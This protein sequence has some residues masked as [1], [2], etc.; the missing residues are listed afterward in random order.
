MN[1]EELDLHFLEYAIENGFDKPAER[2]S[3]DY[4]GEM[5][6]MPTKEGG[7][8][9]PVGHNYR[10]QHFIE[11]NYYTSGAIRLI[12]RYILWHGETGQVYSQLLSPESYKGLARP[13]DIISLHEGS[14]KIG[15]VKIL[16]IYNP[17][18]G[19]NS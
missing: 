12:G 1:N 3:A 16:E 7:R 4:L 5:Y 9:G 15:E 14:K 17:E 8:S 19:K 6:L 13:G 10:P 11:G 2:G 18:F